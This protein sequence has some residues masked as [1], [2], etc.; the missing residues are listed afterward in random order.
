MTVST[1][2]SDQLR[3]DNVA[4]LERLEEAEATIR[5]ISNHEVDAFLVRKGAEE[6]V[7]V[8][9]GV[10]RPYRLRWRRHQLC[11]RRDH[12]RER[13]GGADQRNHRWLN[14]HQ[15]RRCRR[16]DSPRPK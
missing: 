13:G 16:G 1:H 5:A 2:E 14:R 15:H 3:Q 6:Q 11:S 4:L 10:D 7:L 8:L 9:D 12:G